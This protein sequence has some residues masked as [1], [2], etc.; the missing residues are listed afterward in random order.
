MRE[1]GLD[2]SAGR[3]VTRIRAYGGDLSGTEKRGV[4]GLGSG[5]GVDLHRDS[6]A[7]TPDT[8]SATIK[9]LDYLKLSIGKNPLKPRPS[10]AK[11]ASFGDGPDNTW[12]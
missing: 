3:A 6:A 9:S 8:L 5:G 10:A 11:S 7:Q 12:I 1:V 4:L 2:S